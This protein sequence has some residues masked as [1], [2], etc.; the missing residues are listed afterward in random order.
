M[1][2]SLFVNFK[3]DSKFEKK[4]TYGLVSYINENEIHN[5]IPA[6]Y[7]IMCMLLSTPAAS[8]SPEKSLS[9]LRRIKSY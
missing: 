4:Y 1:K 7:K 2:K 6:F 3:T 8:Y 5:I 9:A